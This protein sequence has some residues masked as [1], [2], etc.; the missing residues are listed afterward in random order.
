MGALCLAQQ[1]REALLRIP[2]VLTLAHEQAAPQLHLEY[3]GADAAAN[4]YLALGAIVRAGL[5]GVRREL[6]GPP[7]LER[8]PAG[9]DDADAARYRVG[10]WPA[11]LEDSLRALAED[12]TVRGWLGELLYDAYVGVKRAE[13]QAVAELDPGEVCR[14]YASI[15]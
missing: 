3:R 6:P 15:Y 1:N 9:L 5:D 4:P 14:R 13:L 11:S 2:P 12:D 8:D 7:I 10:Q